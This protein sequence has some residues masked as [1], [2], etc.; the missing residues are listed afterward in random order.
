M[1]PFFSL[2]RQWKKGRV[3]LAMKQ[4][5]TFAALWAVSALSVGCVSGR[6]FSDASI[7]AEK[8]T[9]RELVE[10]LGP[11]AEIVRNQRVLLH[12]STA[13]EYRYFVVDR[14]GEVQ[15]RRYFYDGSQWL[16]S[17]LP[18]WKDRKSLSFRVLDPANPTDQKKLTEFFEERPDLKP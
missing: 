17:R 18:A 9:P 3:P 1:R 7:D 13:Q 10:L 4:V 15:F 16:T 8:K 12:E 14:S 6:W 5:F 2:A 11:P